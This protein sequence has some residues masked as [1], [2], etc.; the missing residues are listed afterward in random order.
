MWI[1][2]SAK[3]S[4]ESQTDQSHLDSDL[5]V[6]ATADAAADRS[7]LICATC[8]E[9]KGLHAP[10]ASPSLFG[11]QENRD[12][13]FQYPTSSS[14]EEACPRH[15]PEASPSLFGGRRI[16]TR[17]FNIQH[18]QAVKKPCPRHAPEASPSLF[19]GRRI[20]T[21][22]FNIQHPQ[23]VKKPAQGLVAAKG[24]ATRHGQSH[25]PDEHLYR[26]QQVYWYRKARWL[27][28]GRQRDPKHISVHIKRYVC[29]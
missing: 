21:R 2:A 14:S 13:K 27:G 7:S 18:P 3:K 19:G 29:T 16:E 26:K 24:K 4:L 11:G 23:A 17:N 15:A 8:P 22:N 9:W 12:S 1:R 20:E 6:G 5:Y 28:G 25:G 10:E